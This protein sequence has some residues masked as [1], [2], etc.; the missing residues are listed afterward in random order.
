MAGLIILTKEAFQV[1]TGHKYGPGTFV[2]HQWSLL[3]KMRE[4]TG[5]ELKNI[6]KLEVV[7]K[8]KDGHDIFCT[9]TNCVVNSKSIAIGNDEIK[10]EI[11]VITFDKPSFRDCGIDY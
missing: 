7:Y 4:I 5:E 3:A 1:T 10:Q 2:T 8:D 11:E 9:F 6:E